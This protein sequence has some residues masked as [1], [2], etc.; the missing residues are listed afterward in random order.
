MA[1]VIDAS[2]AR[3]SRAAAVMGWMRPCPDMRGRIA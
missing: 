1:E 3:A 2:M